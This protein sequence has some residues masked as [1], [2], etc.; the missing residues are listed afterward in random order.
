MRYTVWK[1]FTDYEKEEQWLNEMSAKGMHMVRYTP[2]RYVFE[3][4]PSKQYVYRIQLLDQLPNHPESRA[5]IRFVEE[6]GAEYID[7]ILRWVYFRKPASE[8]DFE[9]YSDLDSR[10][11]HHRSIATMLGIVGGFN[12]YIGL[13]NVLNLSHRMSPSLVWLIP[14][15]NVGL[16]L[17]ILRQ[18][19][20]HVSK[21]GKLKREKDIY[22]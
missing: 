18:V 14:L 4:R 12:V 10:I 17:L 8:G 1:L 9:L 5:Y 22:Q 21:A 3:D 13:V 16:G 7:S 6:S 19:Y 20:S 15:L 11:R 2:L